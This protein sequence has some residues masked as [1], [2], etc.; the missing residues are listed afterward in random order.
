MHHIPQQMEYLGRYIA[1][2]LNINYFDCLALSY[3]HVVRHWPHWTKDSPGQLQR[4]I[5]IYGGSSL[6]EM[7]V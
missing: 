1:Q 6:S 7:G 2:K 5:G 3:R 4:R